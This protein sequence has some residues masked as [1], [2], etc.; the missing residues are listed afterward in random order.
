MAISDLHEAVLTADAEGDLMAAQKLV[1]RLRLEAGRSGDL[2]ERIAAF[3]LL[4]RVFRHRRVATS[5]RQATNA[6]FMALRLSEVP[7]MQSDDAW[8][9]LAE[10]ELAACLI[11]QGE[12]DS[13]RAGAA[14]WR[15]REE[16]YLAGWA[17]TL[18]G[19]ARLGQLRIPEAVAELS[20]AVAEFGRADS[21]HRVFSSRTLLGAALSR[22]GDL[23]HAADLLEADSSHWST[24]DAPRRLRVEHHLVLAE[25]LHARGDI[26]AARSV[27]EEVREELSVCTGMEVTQV[28]WHQQLAACERDWGQLSS[29]G[30]HFSRAEQLRRQLADEPATRPPKNLPLPS[31]AAPA[32]L[33]V[34]TVPGQA[35]LHDDLAA[36]AQSLAA[37]LLARAPTR[38]PEA[39]RL[40]CGQHATVAGEVSS[41][42]GQAIQRGLNSASAVTRL[43]EQ[44]ERLAGVAGETRREAALL[45][46][47]GR[48]LGE[49]EP[50]QLLESERLLRRALI[51]LERLPGMELWLG[52]ANVYLARTLSEGGRTGDALNFALA[53]VG[54]LDQERFRM[55]SYDLR[56][57]WLHEEIHP[58]FNLAIELAHRCARNDIAA[59]L[60]VFSRASGVPGPVGSTSS[61]GRETRLMPVPRLHYIDGSASLLGSG[62]ECRFV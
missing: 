3:R 29:A 54:I 23:T 16:P 49:A 13:G 7:L 2:R 15:S 42:V 25:N 62:G 61:P 18:L 56:R 5:L 11:E 1:L 46:D 24:P 57:N 37:S 21:G 53:G 59:D 47:A 41:I 38:L 10:L 39:V 30:R 22:G 58:A 60:V 8:R 50:Q 26:A 20:N 35:G 44:L 51:R 48:A 43:L 14:A 33:S 40:A 45:V 55:Q 27:L 9:G 32:A 28:Q 6:A 12:Y 4:A 31:P 19:K 34:R 52:R 36:G 17:W